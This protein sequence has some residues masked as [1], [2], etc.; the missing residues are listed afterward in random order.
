M[1]SPA[2]VSTASSALPG[3]RAARPGDGAHRCGQGLARRHAGHARAARRCAADATRGRR[4]RR[5]ARRAPSPT[6]R[7]P[8]PS[9][10]RTPS[11]IV[12][13]KPAGLVV[14]H[15]AGPHG[16]HVGGRPAG[17]L[18]RPGGLAEAAVA[19]SRTGPG[20]CTAWT[21]APRGCWW[22][23][24]P[25]T[26]YRSL[27]QQF[28]AHGAGREYR[29]AGGGDRGGRRA[30]PSTRPSAARRGNRRAW[31]CT[32]RGREARTAVPGRARASRPRSLH[33]ARGE[34]RHGPHP[35]GPRASG[36]HRPPRRRRRPLRT[37]P[38]PA[39]LG[40]G[41]DAGAGRLFLHAFR[42]SLDHPRAA[43]RRGRRRCPPISAPGWWRC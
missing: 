9:C 34:P 36:R 30:A 7:W 6:R 21:R 12:V 23:P 18:P 28:R 40:H 35:P 13:D 25:P 10:T 22:W 14:H 24:A 43:A 32:A 38:G 3:W 16:G 33:P 31:R 2:C 5:R 1:R 41:R 19:T 15:G 20:S 27:A 26:A 17:P 42:L 8:S 29:G 4:V 11:S 39:T 37:A